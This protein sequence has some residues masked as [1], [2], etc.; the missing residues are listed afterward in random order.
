MTEGGWKDDRLSPAPE[1][2]PSA[3]HEKPITIRTTG[4]HST[5]DAH[6][7]GVP[8][9]GLMLPT[10]DLVSA[11]NSD[12]PHSLDGRRRLRDLTDL[13]GLTQL[14]VEL[15]HGKMSHQRPQGTAASTEEVVLS[16]SEQDLG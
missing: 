11:G 3:G 16:Q 1:R 12:Y 8:C 13:L 15:R 2:F 4:I 10:H 7:G 9:A 14:D 6:R 5:R